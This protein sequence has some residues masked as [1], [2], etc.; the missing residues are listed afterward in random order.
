[1]GLVKK[2]RKREKKE[3]GEEGEVEEGELEEDTS[4]KKKQPN[5][6][7]RRDTSKWG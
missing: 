3:D 7:S 1:M 5:N 6:A 2:E 4:T